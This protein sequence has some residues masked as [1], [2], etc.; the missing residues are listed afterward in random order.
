MVMWEEIANKK[1]CEI[2]GSVTI[3]DFII[4][5]YGEVHNAKIDDRTFWDDMLDKLKNDIDTETLPIILSEYNTQSHNYNREDYESFASKTHGIEKIYFNLMQHYYTSYEAKHDASNCIVRSIVR[6][7][8]T[9]KDQTIKN[10][11]RVFD[12][13]LDL[14]LPTSI[15]ETLTFEMINAICKI[16]PND[17]N[18]AIHKIIKVTRFIRDYI[19]RYLPILA[20]FNEN[21]I[22]IY[23]NWFN[24]IFQ[25]ILRQKKILDGVLR[26]PDLEEFF[27]ERDY[28]ING[29]NNINIITS[30]MIFITKN[31][32]I[33][34]SLL[35]DVN[36]INQIDNC[37]N[38]STTNTDS[39]SVG[40]TPFFQDT[41][42]NVQPR[43]IIILAGYSHVKRILDLL[44]NSVIYY[45]NKELEA[46]CNPLEYSMSEN[47]ENQFIKK[48][49]MAL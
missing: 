18:D 12:N 27:T 33:C 7:E 42:V 4:E 23:N 15:E 26:I 38:N 32:R 14:G 22:M 13:R 48:L 1:G 45:N 9:L 43:C 5:L 20:K 40:L 21:G 24:A 46:A 29:I 47:N 34:A 8:Q 10:S 11:L 37:I 39:T 30:V 3:G 41:I 36:I 6:K 31:L 16:K 49:G 17:G 25:A 2:A 35:V 19:S 28:F 44:D